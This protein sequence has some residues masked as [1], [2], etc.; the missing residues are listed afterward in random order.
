MHPFKVHAD[1]K[2][3][4]DDESKMEYLACQLINQEVR[5]TL[6]CAAGEGAE[7]IHDAIQEIEDIVGSGFVGAFLIPSCSCRVLYL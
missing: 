1:L 6:I 3:K 5:Y 4:D 7:Q 2:F